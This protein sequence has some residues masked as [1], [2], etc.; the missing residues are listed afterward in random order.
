MDSIL[1]KNNYLNSNLW[2]RLTILEKRNTETA[3]DQRI[4][5]EERQLYVL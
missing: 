1:L 3:N 2:N 5:I 4:P